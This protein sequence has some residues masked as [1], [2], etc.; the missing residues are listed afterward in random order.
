MVN[1]SE[2]T[3]M[4]IDAKPQNSKIIH[5]QG[6]N[7]VVSIFTIFWNTNFSWLVIYELNTDAGNEIARLMLKIIIN[8]LAIFISEEEYDSL[9]MRPT[10]KAS[11]NPRT[12]EI[13]PITE[14]TN[15]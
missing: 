3:T 9:K 14:K 11:V 1:N 2:A 4:P 10:L 7:T 13:N 12:N 6:P 15:R 8:I 5:V